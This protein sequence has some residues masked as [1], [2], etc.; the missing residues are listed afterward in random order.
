VFDGFK[1]KVV[2]RKF[3]E[4]GGKLKKLSLKRTEGSVQLCRVTT[5]EEHTL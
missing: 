3:V 1:V 5:T 2:F 4:K